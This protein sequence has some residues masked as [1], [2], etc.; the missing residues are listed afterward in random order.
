MAQRTFSYAYN[1]YVKGDDEDLPGL[2]AYALYKRAK[3]AYLQG[4]KVRN[5]KDATERE[6][7]EWAQDHSSDDKIKL[8][9]NQALSSVEK[10][11]QQEVKKAEPEIRKAI[12]AD[13]LGVIHS[14][15][16]TLTGLKAFWSSVGAG[17]VASFF[18][19]PLAGWIYIGLRESNPMGLFNIPSVPP[20]T[21]S[22]SAPAR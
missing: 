20:T 15:V 21:Q 13:H 12:E 17:V 5:G 7:N 8:F 11:R 19:I 22:P 10:Y 2:I 6:I 1:K 16:L 14:K 3:V 18:W 4:Y 9:R